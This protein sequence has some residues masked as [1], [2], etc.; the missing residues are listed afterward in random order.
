M[1]T[2]TLGRTGIRVSHMGMGC[3]NVGR[4][5]HGYSEAESLATLAE[6]LERGVTFYDTAPV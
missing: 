5:L 6:S 4:S 3:S 1:E 2:R